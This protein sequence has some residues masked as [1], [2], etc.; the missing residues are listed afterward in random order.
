MK[1]CRGGK[2]I[3]AYKA[4]PTAT[5]PAGQWFIPKTS[6]DQSTATQEVIVLPQ[7]MTPE[8]MT[9]AI[10]QAINQGVTEQMGTVVEPLMVEIKAMR[11]EIGE[12]KLQLQLEEKKPW[13]KKIFE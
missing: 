9:L 10:K 7:A 4:K 5:V 2:F 3:G 13:W 8:A 12:L 1:R 6:I 11:A